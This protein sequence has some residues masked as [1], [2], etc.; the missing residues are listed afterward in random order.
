MALKTAKVRAAGDSPTMRGTGKPTETFH[1]EATSVVTDIETD[2]DVAFFDRHVIKPARHRRFTERDVFEILLRGISWAA[3]LALPARLWPRIA[4]WTSR[5]RHA[6]YA[7]RKR[8][9]AI[10]ALMAAGLVA[11]TDAAGRVFDTQRRRAHE[12]R[13]VYVRERF[14]PSPVAFDIKGLDE[15]LRVQSEGH[16]AILWT[17]PF[18]FQTLAGKRGLYEAGQRPAQLSATNHG[19]SGSDF[20]VRY[21]NPPIVR[22]ENRYLKERLAFDQ[23]TIATLLRRSVRLLKMGTPVYFGNNTYAGRSFLQV[24]FGPDAWFVM[25]QTPLMLA[26]RHGFTLFIVDTVETE[27]FAAY[28]IRLTKCDVP[29]SPEMTDAQAVAKGALAVRDA[30]L[31]G[32]R[33]APDQFAG[34]DAVFTSP[35]IEVQDQ[36][37]KGAPEP[38]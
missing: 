15:L 18:V 4:G 34:L 24:P 7:R 6:R 29:Q 10:E 14:K 33:A 31:V 36:P 30:I 35:V 3:V 16:G 23:N 28:S 2:E 37:Q 21:L 20:S 8:P 32:A 27:P 5:L 1:Y 13:F 38:G 22:A 26:R 12:Q 25:P 11:D 19:F 17:S 9:A